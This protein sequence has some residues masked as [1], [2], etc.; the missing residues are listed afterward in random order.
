MNIAPADHRS[1]DTSAAWQSSSST[2]PYVPAAANLSTLKEIQRREGPARE[3]LETWG[4]DVRT[5][6]DP[7][8]LFRGP[9]SGPA[10]RNSLHQLARLS[11]DYKNRGAALVKALKEFS[12][13]RWAAPGKTKKF[14]HAAITQD[15]I[16]RFK[17]SLGEGVSFE[18]GNYPVEISSSSS[19]QGDDV[20]GLSTP[21]VLT[22]GRYCR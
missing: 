4:F 16:N 3:I 6:E 1:I 21:R 14:P 18:K 8:P 13:N 5:N 22:K 12:K 20:A 15:D 7:T 11:H 17:E 19:E 9:I 10:G 2:N